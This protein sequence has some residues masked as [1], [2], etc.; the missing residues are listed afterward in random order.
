MKILSSSLLGMTVGCAQCHDH[1][2]DPIT[3]VD[4][5]R[6]R[7]IFDPAYNWE[8]WRAPNSRLYSLY[9]PEERAKAAEIEK[10]AGEI[11]RE[12]QAMTKKF[13]D[14]IFEVEIKKVPQAEQAAFRVARNTPTA[15]QTPEQKVLIKKYPS[16]LATYSLNLYDRR[17]RT[18]SMRKWRRPPNCVPPN[19]QKAS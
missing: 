6:L 16:A 13:L 2:Y 1:R 8:A 5:Y 4:Y 17:S 19:P 18:S 3:Q 12:A 7:A 10:K 9:T 15:K 11:N 14:E